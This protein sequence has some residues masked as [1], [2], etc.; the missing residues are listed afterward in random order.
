MKQKKLNT[1]KNAKCMRNV[2][3]YTGPVL[4]MNDKSR[5][6]QF[7]PSFIFILY[8]ILG[9]RCRRSYTVALHT[10]QQNFPAYLYGKLLI[11]QQR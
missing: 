1:A 3:E 6:I 11:F 10:T 9:I 5:R 4:L 7:S 2:K 8:T